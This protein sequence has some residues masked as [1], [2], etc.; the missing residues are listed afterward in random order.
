MPDMEH[1]GDEAAAQGNH[2][3]QVAGMFASSTDQ[4]HIQP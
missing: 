3:V 4:L 2:E 1:R